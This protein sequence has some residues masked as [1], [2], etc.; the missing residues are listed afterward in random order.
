LQGAAQ[1][2]MLLR[3]G[4]ED[5][6]MRM[7]QQSLMKQFGGRITTEAEA[8][9]G[10]QAAAAQNY[11]QMKMIQSGIFGI[12]GGTNDQQ[13]QHILEAL[14]KGD[15]GTAIKAG[16]D[17]LKDVSDRGISIQQSTNNTLKD[18]YTLWQTS[19]MYIQL[20]AMATVKLATGTGSDELKNIMNKASIKSSNA[21]EED[22]VNR[23]IGR[24]FNPPN[25]IKPE[26]AAAG[27]EAANAGHSLYQQIVKSVGKHMSEVRKGISDAID[28]VNGISAQVNE[29][30]AIK[31]G[32]KP[33][34]IIDHK[35]MMA[36]AAMKDAGMHSMAHKETMATHALG[37]H[38]KMKGEGA[39]TAKVSI[40]VSSAPGLNVKVKSSSKSVNVIQQHNSSALRGHPIDNDPGY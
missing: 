28:G 34:P 16:K 38:T 20:G 35:G 15:M 29:E 19:E 5:Q 23:T 26:M 6:V 1:I 10:G 22:K 31:R 27:I 14:K 13:A 11:T 12:G 36:A 40:E 33:M 9:T 21:L 37:A 18:M 7:A 4:K 17:N 30:A 32:N 24:G 3:A 39:E 2:D 25:N 8:A